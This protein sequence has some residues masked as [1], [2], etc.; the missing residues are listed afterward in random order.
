MSFIVIASFSERFGAQST[1]FP[2]NEHVFCRDCMR[3]YFEVL[4]RLSVDLY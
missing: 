1:I 2:C 4:L 3:S